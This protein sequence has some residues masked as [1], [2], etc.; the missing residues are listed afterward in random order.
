MNGFWIELFLSVLILETFCFLF[1]CFSAGIPLAFDRR[2]EMN[3]RIQNETRFIRTTKS[4]S[5]RQARR[6]PDPSKKKCEDAT[7]TRMDACRSEM[8]A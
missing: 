2:L 5:V 6:Q 8:F 4:A 7:G 3:N 1:F